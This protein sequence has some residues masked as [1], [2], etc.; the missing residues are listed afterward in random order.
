MLSR[1]G[2]RNRTAAAEKRPPSALL[3]HA[4]AGGDCERAARARAYA[5]YRFASTMCGDARAR[6]S[7]PPRAC[8]RKRRSCLSM[9]T[10]CSITR[11]AN[12]KQD[13]GVSSPRVDFER[14]SAF[15]FA[16]AR[17]SANSFQQK[18]AMRFPSIE[19]VRARSSTLGQRSSVRS[20]A[21][22]RAPRTPSRTSCGCACSAPPHA[23]ACTDTT[24]R[25]WTRCKNEHNPHL[26]ADLLRLLQLAPQR[27]RPLP[28][29]SRHAAR[30]PRQ[31]RRQLLVDPAALLRW[32]GSRN[33]ASGTS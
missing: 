10:T 29:F 23:C 14:L 15:S 1:V 17:T 7:I 22:A 32:R 24:M 18:R 8:F 25:T 27:L 11:L 4:K 33:S 2:G 26:L 28:H 31:H 9:S 6:A 16:C 21:C 30:P 12:C 13:R 19:V 5:R 3:L 20:C